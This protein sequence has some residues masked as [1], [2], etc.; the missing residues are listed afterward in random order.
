MA[1]KGFKVNE[2]VVVVYQA[3]GSASGIIVDMDVYD[4]TGTLDAGQCGTMTEIG[5]TG[6]YRMSFTPDQEGTW[7][8]RITDASGGKA[9]KVYSVGASNVSEIGV[10]VASIDAK[11]TDLQTAI[12]DL[13]SPPMIA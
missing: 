3:S 1:D 11:V 12:T 8:V 6:C 2:A 9:T 13:E 10:A 5:T 4:E 7:I